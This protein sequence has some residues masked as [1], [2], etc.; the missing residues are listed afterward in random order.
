MKVESFFQRSYLLPCV[1]LAF[2]ILWKP[3]YSQSKI[4][5]SKATTQ[6]EINKCSEQQYKSAD[7][8]LNDLYKKVLTKLDA[9]QKLALIQSQRK[10]VSFRDEYAKVYQSIF[11]EGSM[12]AS[13]VVKCKT[14]STRSRIEELRVL[15]DEVSL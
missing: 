4:D 12:L 6:V 13:A 2:N 9:R 1:W 10:W 11:N 15:L 5:C 7:K 14:G 8:E 3:A